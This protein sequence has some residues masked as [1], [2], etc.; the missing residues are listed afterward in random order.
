[1]S[2][3]NNDKS[4][5]ACLLF[6]IFEHFKIEHKLYPEVVPLWRL[7]PEE[8]GVYQAWPGPFEGRPAPPGRSSAQWQCT[9][10]CRSRPPTPPAALAAGAS[11]E[12]LVGVGSLLRCFTPCCVPCTGA[13]FYCVRPAYFPQA[14]PVP[15][16]SPTYRWWRLADANMKKTKNNIYIY[17]Y[18][19]ICVYVC[20]Y[21]CIYIYISIYIYIYISR[22]IGAG[23]FASRVGDIP[24]R[25]GTFFDFGGAFI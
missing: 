1:M 17:I 18:I 5:F 11:A 21:I 12:A 10:R 7:N 2:S 9:L 25:R 13:L 8:L 14:G 19:C 16:T 4:Y 3:T 24:G 23:A 20:I 15:T 22:N 6:Q